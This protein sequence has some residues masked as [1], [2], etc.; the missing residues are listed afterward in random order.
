MQVLLINGSPHAK[1]NTYDA[2]RI[3]EQELVS[4]N[5]TTE[6]IQLGGINIK[7]CQG[8]QTCWQNKDAK[9]VICD[10]LQPI[11]KKCFDKNT[12]CIV[13]GSPTYFSNV[14]AETKAFIDRVGYVAK[15]NNGLLR[16]K[17]GA[18]V[19]IDRRAG[20]NFVYSAINFF[21]GINEMVIATSSYWN[22]GK[23]RKSHELMNDVEGVQTFKTL[24]QNIARLIFNDS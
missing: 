20:A 2:L 24:A 1:G 18:P 9:C 17:I 7:G 10:D 15:A 19:V 13:I 8:C 21:F 4:K 23:A 12:K 6:I 3:V 16:Y 22:S 11:M 5:I 14:T